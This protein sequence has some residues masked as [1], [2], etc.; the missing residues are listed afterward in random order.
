MVKISIDLNQREV[1]IF[2]DLNQMDVKIFIDLNASKG[3]KGYL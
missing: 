3:K 1:M 2:I